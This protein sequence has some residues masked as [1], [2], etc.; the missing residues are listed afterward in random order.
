MVQMPVTLWHLPKIM[1]P[2]PQ[3]SPRYHALRIQCSAEYHAADPDYGRPLLYRYDVITAGPH[4]QMPEIMASIP[5]L[6][7]LGL[8]SAQCREVRP[9]GFGVCRQRRH[10]HEAGE[11]H[12]RV[13]CC[14][15]EKAV[16][17]GWNDTILA[18]FTANIDLQEGF[19]R[20]IRPAGT[21]TG[22]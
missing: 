4:G 7:Q 14:L 10:G 21:P 2:I 11:V 3:G 6:I 16:N 22:P 15:L 1:P 9:D 20:A 12:L 8:Q 13:S 5:F 18:L 17:F 19:G